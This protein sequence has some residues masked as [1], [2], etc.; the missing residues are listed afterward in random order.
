[1]IH[2]IQI[3]FDIEAN[4]HQ[5]AVFKALDWASVDNKELPEGTQ[6]FTVL[7]ENE[8]I[9]PCCNPNYRSPK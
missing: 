4:S 5:E 1:M 8:E 3:D 6:D 2:R 7:E 9:C